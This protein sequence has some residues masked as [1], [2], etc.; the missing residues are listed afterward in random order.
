MKPTQTL[1]ALLSL[2]SAALFVG[3]AHG[4]SPNV[5]SDSAAPAH[6]VVIVELF[7]SEGCSSCPPA[8]ALLKALSE[9][10]SNP[11]LEIIALEEHVDYWDNQGWK[12]PFS[13]I[14][15]TERQ[16]DYVRTL[17]GKGGAYTPQMIVDGHTEVIG[18]RSREAAELIAKAA[19]QPKANILLSPAAGSANGKAAFEIKVSGLADT[20]HGDAAELWIAITEKGLHSDVKAG[21]NSGSTLQHA[22]VVRVIKSIDSFRGPTDHEAHATIKLQKS[23]N[24][25]NLA[26]VAFV[27]DKHS[28]AI[29]G[30]TSAKIS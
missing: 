6:R 5:A 22:P 15:F 21:E 8:D 19:S 25:E 14:E 17:G 10:Q 1:A 9:Q 12:D 27:V 4:H 16:N 26:F 29:I 18:S 28:R 13:S 20:L 11:A 7:T 24:R 23:W 30:A 3:I 2:S